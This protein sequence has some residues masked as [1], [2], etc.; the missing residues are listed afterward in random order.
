MTFYLDVLGY[1]GSC[2][3]NPEDVRRNVMPDLMKR[4]E[5]DLTPVKLSHLS[6]MR[7]RVDIW[8]KT[9]DFIIQQKFAEFQKAKGNLTLWPDGSYLPSIGNYYLYL[10]T[11]QMYIRQASIPSRLARPAMKLK[12]RLK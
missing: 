8:Q 4:I 11:C 5:R 7:N 1:D 9:K 12:S 2:C 10:A 6:V 3:N